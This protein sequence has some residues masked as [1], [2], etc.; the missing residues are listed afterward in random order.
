MTLFLIN[1]ININLFLYNSVRLFYDWLFAQQ[2]LSFWKKYLHFFAK[3][4]KILS[5][6]FQEFQEKNTIF[7][8]F[9]NS[10][11][12]KKRGLNSNIFNVKIPL[13]K[14]NVKQTLLVLMSEGIKYNSHSTNSMQFQSENC[15][16]R[17]KIF[18]YMKTGVDCFI[19]KNYG[20]V[21]NKCLS[22]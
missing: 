8:N 22:L 6:S 15:V 18:Y 1:R 20:M 7:Q 13:C 10:H 4:Y 12:I 9:Q 2:S 19:D 3:F 21:S 5:K 14:N 11:L 17:F 16:C